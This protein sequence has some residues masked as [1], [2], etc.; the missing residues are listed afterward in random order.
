MLLC[1]QFS[2]RLSK[3]SFREKSLTQKLA[4]AEKRI[5]DLEQKQAR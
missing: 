1:L 5:L 2:V 3:M 4:I